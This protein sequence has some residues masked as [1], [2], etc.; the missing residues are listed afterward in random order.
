METHEGDADSVIR[1]RM[2]ERNELE[3]AAAVRLFDDAATISAHARGG[4]ARIVFRH[5]QHQLRLDNV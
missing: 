3:F 4:A 5:E 2:W 1:T